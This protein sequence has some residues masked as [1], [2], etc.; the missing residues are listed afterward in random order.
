MSAFVGLD[1]RRQNI[2]SI[3]FRRA[4]LRPHQRLDFL[5]CRSVI[6]LCFDRL[7]LHGNTSNRLRIDRVVLR[8][9]PNESDVDEI[10][11]FHYP[12]SLILAQPQQVVIVRNDSLRSSFQ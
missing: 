2:Q 12:N 3:T 10:H 1:Q 7:D 5:E 9:C 6:L 11:N 8:M 4:G